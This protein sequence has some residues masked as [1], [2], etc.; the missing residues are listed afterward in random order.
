L[1]R[2]TK[3]TGNLTRFVPQQE[4]RGTEDEN[5]ERKLYIGDENRLVLMSFS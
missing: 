1:N 5:K 4:M 3:L 2:T